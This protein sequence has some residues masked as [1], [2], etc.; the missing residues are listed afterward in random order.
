MLDECMVA[1]RTGFRT[2]YLPLSS[3]TENLS[4]LAAPELNSPDR[5]PLLLRFVAKAADSIEHTL[6]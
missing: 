2:K 3:Q 6:W 5:E 4:G 1:D